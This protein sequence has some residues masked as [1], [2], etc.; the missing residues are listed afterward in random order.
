MNMIKFLWDEY[1]VAKQCSEGMWWL[2][3]EP[4]PPA[5]FLTIELGR[6]V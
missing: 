3:A 1:R 6:H 5:W 2:I 4:D